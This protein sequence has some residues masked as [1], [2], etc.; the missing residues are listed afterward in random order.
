MANYFTLPHEIACCGFTS[1]FPSPPSMI[2]IYENGNPCVCVPLLDHSL[3]HKIVTKAI[4]NTM[5][6]RDPIPGLNGIVSMWS[7]S[8]DILPVYISKHLKFKHFLKIVDFKNEHPQF[9]HPS[10]IC[11]NHWTNPPGAKGPSMQK[12]ADLAHDLP[13]MQRREELP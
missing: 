3:L 10:A 8:V 13:P 11:N 12:R 2:E 5:S 9:L 6:R 1:P 7:I 4:A